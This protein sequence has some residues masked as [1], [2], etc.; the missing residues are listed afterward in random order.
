MPEINHPNGFSLLI[1]RDLAR[2]SALAYESVIPGAG[3]KVLEVPGQDLRALVSRCDT[4]IEIA[5]RGTCDLENWILDLDVCKA[6][7]AYGVKVHDGFL[8]AAEVLL[9]LLL[10]ELLPPGSE[11]CAWW[12]YILLARRGWVT[13]L[14]ANNTTA[15]RWLVRVPTLWIRRARFWGIYLT[16]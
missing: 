3:I 9:P 13:R 4:H 5:F 15:R 2:F 1:A 10:A 16:G 12:R 6:P 14:S 8:R 11:V 7:L